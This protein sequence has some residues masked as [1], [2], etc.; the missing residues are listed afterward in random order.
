LILLAENRESTRVALKKALEATGYDVIVVEHASEVLS[1]GVG[2]DGHR[3]EAIET[4]RNPI[5]SSE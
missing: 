3:D 4:E 5:P 1:V 2:Y